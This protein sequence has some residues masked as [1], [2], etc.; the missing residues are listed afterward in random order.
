M[1]RRWIKLVM[2]ERL[3]NSRD[4][5]GWSDGQPHVHVAADAG[6]HVSCEMTEGWKKSSEIIQKKSLVPWMQN[7]II[8][9]FCITIVFIIDPIDIA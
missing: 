4:N 7:Q 8:I 9:L 5:D 3:G 1:K 2:R 6:N